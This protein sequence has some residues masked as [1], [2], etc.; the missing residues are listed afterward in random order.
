MAGAIIK[1]IKKRIAG[2]VAKKTSP[3]V[4]PSE[5]KAM[6]VLKTAMAKRGK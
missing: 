1:S 6:K 3:E 2:G 5:N 4:K